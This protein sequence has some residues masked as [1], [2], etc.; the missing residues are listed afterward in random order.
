VRTRLE[1]EHVSLRRRED[2]P[3]LTREEARDRGQSVYWLDKACPHG[4]LTWRYVS[5]GYCVLCS[6]R[7]VRESHF[8]EQRQAGRPRR[9]LEERLEDLELQRRLYDPLYDEDDIP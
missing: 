8:A 1:S 5:N 2:L 9:R 6:Y 4:H 7:S 3:K